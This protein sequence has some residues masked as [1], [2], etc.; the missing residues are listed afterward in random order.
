MS[1]NQSTQ[2]QEARPPCEVACPVHTEVR[3]YINAIARGDYEESYRL[4]REPNPFP[5]ICGRVCAHP[6]EDAC[7]RAQVDEPIAIAALKRFAT[8]HHDLKLGHG[9]A[10]GEVQPK[11][12]R[13]AIV[14]SG[15]AGMA[16]A[17]DLVRK[18]YQVTVFEA[19]N[20]IGGM[21]GLGLPRYR[22]PR[23]IIHT[24]LDPILEM[25]VEV[26]KNTRLGT[27]LTLGDLRDQGYD[28]I[29]IAVGGQLSRGL[30]IEGA[31]LEGVLGGVDFLRDINLGHSVSLGKKILVIG[32]GNV[33]VDVARSAV[34]QAPLGEKEVHMI[35]LESREEMPAHEWEI[36]EAQKEGI[37]LHPSKGPHRI[38]G[39]DGHVVGLET[40]VCTRVFDESGRFNPSFAPN[41][42]EVIEGDTI[43]LAIGQASD[44]SFLRP[45]DGVELT[46]RGTIA[47]DKNTL[48]TSAPGIFAGGEVVSGPDLVIGATASGQRAAAAI[49]AY[50]QGIDLSTLEFTEP[51]ELPELQVKTIDKIRPIGRDPMPSLPLEERSANYNE[52]EL[53]Y[54]EWMAVHAAH[55]CLT[56]GGGAVV[57][58]A[59]CTA[60][61]TCVRICPYEVPTINGSGVAEIDIS[62]CQACGL[63]AAECPAKAITLKLYP[64]DE[65][66]Q[67]IQETLASMPKGQQEPTILGFSCRYCIYGDE[68]SKQIVPTEFPDNVR[69]IEVLC[70][71][72]I[73]ASHLLT[74]FELG[75]DGVFVAGCLEEN[76][77]NTTGSHH[78]GRRT[79]FVKHLL[80][81]VGL[82]GD[83]LE[84]HH[85]PPGQCGNVSGIASDL[86]AKVQE[87]GPNPLK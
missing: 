17:H 41:T 76:C 84:M 74:A 37:I 26:R 3:G 52:V 85:L 43:I 31:D 9:P 62:Q 38:L 30:R 36:E 82:G 67:Q 10:L 21:L 53:G 19:H 69:T 8:D 79:E 48:A 86:A 15:P 64:E 56:C 11:Q 65:L 87:L 77:H 81:E 29:F 1:A 27:D 63:C 2:A 59:K 57:D 50:L 73:D 33:A 58:A 83:R 54:T 24:D 72:R 12:Q 16:A 55:R 71:G 45:E 13:V 44:T 75:A 39:K 35:C 42:E 68:D 66:T 34:R 18:G 46:R 23:D 20:Q 6:C 22:L 4:A 5:Y 49:D 60:C 25:G 47:V 51:E 32:G 28:A 70:T 61:L 14:G 40:V 7:R 80:D 78:A